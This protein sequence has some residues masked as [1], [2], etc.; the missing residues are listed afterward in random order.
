MNGC[1]L[2]Q[3]PALKLSCGD[4]TGEYFYQGRLAGAILPYQCMDF[5]GIKV[6]RHV[7]KSP[8]SRVLLGN[9][10]RAK[11][12]SGHRRHDAHGN[13]GIIRKNRNSFAGRPLVF[14]N[15]CIHLLQ[16]MPAIGDNRVGH[17]FARHIYWLEKN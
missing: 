7:F 8:N 11:Q 2:Q 14:G 17:V 5:S 12:T 1:A 13:E 6:K 9:T 15:V 16:G 3:N 4:D 10:F